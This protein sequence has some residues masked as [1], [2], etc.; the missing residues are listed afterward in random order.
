MLGERLQA[1]L[2]HG[3][4][5]STKVSYD[6]K[7]RRFIAFCTETLPNAYGLRPR[8]HLPASEK[9][10]LM[11]LAH[12]SNEGKVAEQSLQ[13]YLSA[14]NQMHEDAGFPKP[15]C[16]HFVRLLRRGY[17]E[18]EADE[19]GQPLANRVPA[20]AELMLDILRLGLA[21]PD[22]NIL[23]MCTCLV[24]SFCWFNR[25][26]T[27]VR[28]QRRHVSVTKLGIAIN[29]Q[30]KTIARNTSHTLLRKTDRSSDPDGLV[31]QL[32]LRWYAASAHFQTADSLFWSLRSEQTLE[33]P[34]VTK[35]LAKC[36]TLTGWAAPAGEKWTG[37]SLR[38]G[39]ASACQAIDV[40]LF[41]IM[42][43]GVWRSMEAVQRYLS[44]LILPSDDAWLF[45]GWLRPRFSPTLVRWT[46]Q[47]SPPPSQPQPPPQQQQPPQK[48]PQQQP[49]PQ[50]VQQQPAPPQ[51]QQQ[52]PQ[53]RVAGAA[54]Q[55]PGAPWPTQGAAGMGPGM[56]PRAAGA[57]SGAIPPQPQ[58]HMVQR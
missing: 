5:L 53:A 19:R 50:Q 39:G 56:P 7:Q 54:G 11:Y 41:Y 40:P 30:G 15:A 31:D 45:F 3:R 43:F 38:S 24:L 14:V 12:L 34:I 10:I 21:T 18:L 55:P 20:P 36:A 8:S 44:A 35:W 51:A 4:R 1:L 32:L 22:L 57:P 37:H 47:Q 52:P 42:S 33:A 23:R 17:I 48:P 25:A 9:T 6:G 49:L 29:L 2:S 46:Q 26:D 16:G 13:P 27:G 28:L 58:Q